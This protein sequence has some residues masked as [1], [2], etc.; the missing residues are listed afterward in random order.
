LLKGSLLGPALFII[1]VINRTTGIECTLSQFADD[2]RLCSTVIT[3]EGSNAIQ[4]DLD[5][6]EKCAHVNLIKFNRA[7][8][9]VLHM[10]QGNPKDKYRLGGEWSDS[11]PKEGDLGVLVDEKLDMTQ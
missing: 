1:F 10:G 9:K 11:S 2:T 5:R 3:L 7:K 4:R 6:L 8:N